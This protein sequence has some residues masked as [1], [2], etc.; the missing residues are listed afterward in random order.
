MR[1]SPPTDATGKLQAVWK[2]KEQLRLLLRINSLA[3]AP[4]AKEDLKVLVDAAGRPET[5]KLYRPCGIAAD[6]AGARRKRTSYP[7]R[8]PTTTNTDTS[9]VNEALRHQPST[10]S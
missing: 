4:A 6:P 10:K 2:V 3:D 5:N 1:S 9:G 8:P 7:P